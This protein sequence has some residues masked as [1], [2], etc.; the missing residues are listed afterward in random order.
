MNPLTITSIFVIVDD[1]LQYFFKTDMYKNSKFIWE[2]KTGTKKKLSLSE[3][4]SLNIIRYFFRVGDLKTFHSMAISCLKE[5]FP[6]MPNYEN[7]LKAT[8][9]SIFYLNIFLEFLLYVNK[10]HNCQNHYVDSTDLPVCRNHNIFKHR[11]TAEY[12]SRGKTTK[13]WFYG[14]K[15]HGVC[16]DLREL[17]NILFTTGSTHD[18]IVLHDLVNGLD[19]IFTC[20]AGY[21]LKKEDLEKFYD[22]CKTLFIATRKNMKR[23]MTKEQHDHFKRRSVIENIWDVLKERFELVYNL[24]RSV[25]GL[26][27]HYMFSI[28]SFLLHNLIQNKNV[29]T[30][31]N[32]VLLIN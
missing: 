31:K 3:V 30:G 13:G 26:F 32:Q 29:K 15:L 2:N 5:Y 4:V 25:K 1:F 28:T 21:L 18:N 16:N 8:N 12:A 11:V 20:D 19:G 9:K 6:N 17:E 23:P 27:R 10:E 14:F 24:A 22:E 7:F